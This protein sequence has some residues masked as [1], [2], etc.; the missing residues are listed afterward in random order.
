[1]A[2]AI[3]PDNW[4]VDQYLLDRAGNNDIQLQL[5]YSYGSNPPL[6]PQWQAYLREHQPPTLLVWGKHDKIFP[7]EGAY[8]YKRDLKDLEFHLLDTGHFA[9][10][11]DGLVI[12]AHIRRFLGTRVAWGRP[13]QERENPS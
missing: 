11:E 10:E 7:A 13:S 6:Y 12:A 3:S 9:L 8:P 1:D 5:F 4:L 2:E